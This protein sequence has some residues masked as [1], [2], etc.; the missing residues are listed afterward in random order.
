MHNRIPWAVWLFPSVA[1]AQPTAGKLEVDDLPIPVIEM[2]K[3]NAVLVPSPPPFPKL[4]G[5]G[6]TRTP[7]DLRVNSKAL[8]HTRV[9]VKG[10]ITWI[11]DCIAAVAAAHPNESRAIVEQM[12]DINPTQCERAKFYLGDARETP[13]AESIWVVDV[14]RPPYRIERE[15]LPKEDLAQWPEVPKLAIGNHVIVTGTWAM[16]SPHYERNT[17]GLL[18]YGSLAPVVSEFADQASATSGVS[19]ASSEETEVAVVTQAPLRPFITMQTYN[20][21]VDFL[22]ECNRL[23]T[24]RQYQPAIAACQSATAVWPGNHHAWYMTASIHQATGQ[25]QLAKDAIEHAVTLRPDVG[26][27]QLRYGISL[28]ELARQQLSREQARQEKLREERVRLA[29]ERLRNLRKNLLQ[30]APLHFSTADISAPAEPAAPPKVPSSDAFEPA[31]QA[32]VRASVIEPKLW[33]ATF[34]LGR[35]HEERGDPGR[36]A[37]LFTATIAAN[38]TYRAS[39]VQLAELYRRWGFR[40]PSIAIASLGLTQV[41]AAE[42]ADLW[43]EIGLA[44]EAGQDIASAYRAYSR[45][46][47]VEPAHGKARFQR[48]QLN[49]RRRNYREAKRDLQLVVRSDDLT[50]AEVKPVA[51]QLLGRL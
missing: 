36:A 38:P 5:H 34:Y 19:R 24:A 22:N 15:E 10:Y 9:R 29:S 37:E 30:A 33:R 20:D 43:L 1:F 14:P 31:R 6:G 44:H 49:V 41:P 11:Y 28:F 27:Y 48:G 16:V 7:L 42:T 13:R 26:M 32:L 51:A 40:N 2:A 45:A 18:I 47:A 3:P 17:R 8:L 39:Y 21:S 12:I 50:L 4:T 25:W 35:L 23:V 46:I